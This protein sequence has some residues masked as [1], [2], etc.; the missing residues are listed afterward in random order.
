[1]GFLHT[2]KCYVKLNTSPLLNKVEC[3]HTSQLGS[4][5]G[6]GH[7]IL[8]AVNHRVGLSEKTE[9]CLLLMHG[10]V[11]TCHCLMTK[12]SR[13]QGLRGTIHRYTDDKMPLGTDFLTPTELCTDKAAGV[14][15]PPCAKILKGRSSI[16]TFVYHGSWQQGCMPGC[17]PGCMAARMYA[18]P[19]D[20]VA[21][22][23]E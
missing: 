4:D 5:F 20:Q 12:C 18:T 16:G 3:S 22:R 6:H 23:T 11:V 21:S 8:L 1:M 10:L 19:Q 7:L 2:T 13:R 15:M 14:K 9:Y 17:M